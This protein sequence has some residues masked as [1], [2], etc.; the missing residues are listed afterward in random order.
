MNSNIKPIGVEN[1]AICKSCGGK[2]C[3]TYPG[4]ATPE[5]FGAPDIEKLR[6]N[7]IEALSTGM[8]T[9]DWINQDEGLYFVRP[10]VKGFEG[11]VFDHNYL[12]ECT[13]LT[14]H[15]CELEFEKR[16]ESCRMLVPKVDERC[17]PQGYTRQTVARRWKEYYDILMDA[18]IEVEEN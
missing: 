8:W 13:F 6:T 16:P 17:D 12:G 2:C 1:L 9:I 14:P 4:P 18:A 10:A 11:S 15:G 3:K 7:L 5:D